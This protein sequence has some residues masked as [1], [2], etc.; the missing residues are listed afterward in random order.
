MRVQE[1]KIS[2]IKLYSEELIDP[3]TDFHYAFHKSLK[4]IT[5]IH[6]HNF[7]ELFLV[8]S[9]EVIHI[10]NEKA[11]KIGEGTLVFIRENDIHYYQRSDQKN[12]NL[13]NLAFRKSTLTD[14]FEY[15]GEGYSSAQLYESK[16]PPQMLLTSSE[17]EILAAKMHNLN[18]FDR[19]EKNKIKTSLR[20]LLFEIF[21]KYF[22]EQKA[23]ENEFVPKWFDELKNQ[24]QK[25][26]NFVLGI[27]AFDKL[28]S[29]TQEHICRVSKKYLNLTPTEFVNE[30]RLNYAANLLANSDESISYISFE[31][32]FEN[33]S[34][35]YH[36]FKKKFSV[37]PAE[38]RKENQKNIIPS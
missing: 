2:R 8:V 3:E 37:S 6:H 32:G 5:T 13:I 38:F 16:M 31:S 27:K 25:K 1:K 21:T 30:L 20:I 24:M 18:T 34:H 26:E 28:T 9:G 14:L 23:D 22:A 7:Y 35:F 29:K 4:N 19:T 10:I 12:C 33:L 36:L 17:T 15:L 11:Q